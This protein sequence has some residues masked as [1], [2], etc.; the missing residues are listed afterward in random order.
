MVMG[1]QGRAGF[2][3]LQ[4][5]STAREVVREAPCPVLTTRAR[6]LCAKEIGPRELGNRAADGEAGWVAV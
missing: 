2:E 3:L 1:A 6:D 5:G 4:F